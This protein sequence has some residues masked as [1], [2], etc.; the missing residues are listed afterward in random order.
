MNELIEL[1]SHIHNLTSDILIKY[2]AGLEL[3]E[4]DDEIISDIY[5]ATEENRLISISDLG[6]KENLYIKLLIKPKKK[7]K[8]KKLCQKI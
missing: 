7:R 8:T 1:I 6:Q 5:I 3:S 2:Y 4:I